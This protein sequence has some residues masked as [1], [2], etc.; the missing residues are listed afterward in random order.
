M[1]PLERKPPTRG[2]Q[3][4]SGD[5]RLM[6]D[7]PR[8]FRD[9]PT[10]I[11]YLDGTLHA[12]K[13]QYADQLCVDHSHGARSERG[14]VVLIYQVITINTVQLVNLYHAVFVQ[15]WIVRGRHGHVERIT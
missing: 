5:L 13:V 9:H 15:G 14:D 11:S 2:Y 7:S 10:G 1:A 12:L 3:E 4:E 6:R 8:W